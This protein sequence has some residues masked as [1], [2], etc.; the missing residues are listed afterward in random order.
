[1]GQLQVRRGQCRAWPFG[2]CGCKAAD[3]TYTDTTNTAKNDAAVYL[4][5]SASYDFGA[6]DRKYEGVSAAFAVRNIADERPV[7][8]N[9]GY[10]Y[11]GQGRNITASLKRSW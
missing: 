11:L 5:A 3:A 9:S 8:C 4:D 1:M 7:V 6:I 2:R 10:C